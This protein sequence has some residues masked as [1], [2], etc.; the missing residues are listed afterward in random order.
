MV[1]IW[2]WCRALSNGHVVYNIH[3]QNPVG[4]TISWK[5]VLEPYWKPVLALLCFFL[6]SLVSVLTNWEWWSWSLPVGILSS[7]AILHSGLFGTFTPLKLT[8]VRILEEDQMAALLTT[9]LFLIVQYGRKVPIVRKGGSKLTKLM[10]RDVKRTADN[11]D[12]IIVRD[13]P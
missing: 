1:T 4:V 3:A 13:L 9:V 7:F 8:S 11:G 12:V 5:P 6:S 2:V 10:V